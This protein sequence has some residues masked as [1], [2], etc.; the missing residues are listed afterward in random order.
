MNYEKEIN[1]INVL[2]DATNMP[3]ERNGEKM[4]PADRVQWLIEKNDAL[5]LSRDTKASKT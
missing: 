1:K 3:K 4:G 2:L 5:S